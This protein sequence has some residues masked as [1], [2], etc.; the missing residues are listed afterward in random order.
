MTLWPGRANSASCRPKIS[1]VRGTDD[2][3]PG[4]RDGR[5]QA[6]KMFA[7]GV[8][9]AYENAP[10]RPAV[11]S[12]DPGS[13]TDPGFRVECVWH[14]RQQRR[15]RLLKVFRAIEGLFFGSGAGS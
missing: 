5:I 9:H 11:V 8:R 15:L 14:R 12:L 7:I 13:T 3:N 2:P 6:W 10:I 1:D 4:C